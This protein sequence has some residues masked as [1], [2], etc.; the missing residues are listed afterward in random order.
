MT[1]IE[2]GVLYHTWFVDRIRDEVLPQL[3]IVLLFCEF[4]GFVHVPQLLHDHL[5]SPSAI[6]HPAWV[7]RYIHCFLV[8]LK[9]GEMRA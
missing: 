4:Y 7:Q 2:A 1:N 5:Q 9:S 6:P 8:A 3:C